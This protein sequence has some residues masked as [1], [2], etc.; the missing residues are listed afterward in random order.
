MSADQIR[1]Q[2]ERIRAQH[3]DAERKVG[4]YQTR[5]SQKR[6]DASRARSAAARATSASTSRTK[7]N[8]ADRREKE[9]EAAGK[10]ATQW[11]QKATK[12]GK[13]V[14]RLL[15]DLDRAEAAEQRAA[16]R[17]RDR[18]QQLRDRR[19][20]VAHTALSARVTAAEASVQDLHQSLPAPKPEKLRV[21]ILTSSGE[22]DL[23]VGREVRQIRGAVQA[24]VLRDFVELDVRSA[25]TPKD[26]LDGIIEFRPHVVHF[27]GHSNESFVVFEEDTDAHNPGIAIPAG[28]FARAMAAVDT[29]P[30]LV[31]FN[32]CNS[33]EQ[34]AQLVE[35]VVPF[36]I[37]MADS[38][39]DGDAIRYA[40]RFY[41]AIAN[42]QSVG[43]AH[44]VA[45][46]DLEMQGSDRD[47]LPTLHAGPGYDPR[48]AALVTGT[49]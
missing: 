5:E 20:A 6:A 37:G 30:S 8:E 11:Q 22:G 33:A 29:P 47:D 45:R 32:S 23:R 49:V 24:A 9:A 31:I 16:D 17:K 13:E 39:E 12:Y 19:Q 27:S 18:E 43:G 34:A 7:S 2:L 28:V 42:G 1:R 46:T 44:E 41:G 25:A 26:L 3:N 21:L 36:A 40:A 10:Q 35:G 48:D 4:E 15:R 38:V 14:G